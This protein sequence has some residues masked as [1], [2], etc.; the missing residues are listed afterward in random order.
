[1]TR[2]EIYVFILCLIVFLLLTGLAIFSI[3][4][5]VK[6]TLKLIRSGAE[7][8]KLKKE[9]E[10]EKLKKSSRFS[11]VIDYG[12]SLILCLFFAGLFSVSTYIN[13]TQNTY[14]EDVPTY[15]VVESGSMAKKHAKNK[16]LFDNNLNNQF[17]TFSLIATYKIPDEFE[18][19]LYDIVVYE[20]DDILLVHRIVGIEEPN[21]KHPDCRYFLLQGDAVEA[22]D[23]F[24]VLYSQ[25]RGIYKGENIPFVGSFVLFLQSPAGWLCMLLVVFAII[26]TPIIENIIKKAKRARLA[27]LAALLA[28]TENAKEPEPIV[29]E[30]VVQ[31]PVPV[32]MPVAMPVVMPVAVGVPVALVQQ[33]QQSTEENKPEPNKNEK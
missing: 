7:D 22:P 14:F 8:D 23:R 2:Y 5:I 13:C 30:K 10:K 12:I 20:V 6:L 16:Y 9:A 21:E 27:L 15:R 4:L 25:M 26:A 11:K 32:A 31:V 1:M 18:L 29:I 33:Q 3:A 28:E 24:P 17:D 19:K